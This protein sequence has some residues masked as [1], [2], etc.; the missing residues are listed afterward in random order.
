M[1]SCEFECLVCEHR[2]QV[3]VSPEEFGK[4]EIYCPNCGSKMI[5]VDF[6]S[7]EEFILDHNNEYKR[8]E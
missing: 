7:N 6:C 3:Y 2:M 8:D 1:P 5:P 4:Q